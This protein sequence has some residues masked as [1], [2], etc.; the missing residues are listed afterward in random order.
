[1]TT[2]KQYFEKKPLKTTINGKSHITESWRSVCYET[3]EA[4]FQDF[5]DSKGEK[6]S[7]VRLASVDKCICSTTRSRGDIPLSNHLW[8]K[9]IYSQKDYALIT[10]DI[11]QI[12]R[13]TPMMM[14]I[15][16]EDDLDAYFEESQ[17][18]TIKEETEEEPKTETDSDPET[19]RSNE[20]SDIEILES[21]VEEVLA[22]V[23]ALNVDVSKKQ[24]KSKE[25][26]KE[27]IEFSS[28]LKSYTPE[29]NK[30]PDFAK[31]KNTKKEKKADTE[32]YDVF[33]SLCRLA[34]ENKR[35]NKYKIKYLASGTVSDLRQK[36]SVVTK[37][38]KALLKP[39]LKNR[40]DWSEKKFL[41]NASFVNE[42]TG[43]IDAE[44]YL[45]CLKD[46]A[47]KQDKESYTV[48]D[49]EFVVL[50][51]N[52]PVGHT[53]FTVNGISLCDKIGKNFVEISVV[54]DN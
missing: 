47:A 24:E 23:T 46:K 40:P 22:D 32:K 19:E 28:V 8:F 20:H 34:Y 9:G 42:E 48:Q 43:I 13:I 12:Y 38:D 21:E 39:L 37:Q 35:N 15:V 11:C 31:P 53:V 30:L 36:E 27:P 54:S 29:I 1:M 44:A 33:D 17:E 10:N 41:Y 7:G 51:E 45:A 52:Q 14:S 5:G 2:Q 26:K 18:E 6:V 25:Q 49:I 16:Y 4:S 50:K 3:L